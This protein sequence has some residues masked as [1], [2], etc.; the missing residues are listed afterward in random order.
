VVAAIIPGEIGIREGAFIDNFGNGNV[1]VAIELGV[2]PSRIKTITHGRAVVRCGVHGDAQVEGFT[3]AV[4][5][6][7]VGLVAQKRLVVAVAT[8]YPLEQVRDACI[9]SARRHARGKILLSVV[10]EPE[11][12]S[13]RPS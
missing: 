2:Q 7:L 12:L 1:D 5:E 13:E 3:P 8:V 4:V 9:E 11:R 10:P 6:E